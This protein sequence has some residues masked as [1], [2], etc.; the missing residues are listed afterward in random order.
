M[1][2]PEPSDSELDIVACAY[3]S[4]MKSLCAHVDPRLAISSYP[5]VL[6]LSVYALDPGV[7]A[8]PSTSSSGQQS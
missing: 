8:P 3:L 4:A 2:L 1:N 5:L 6:L 7:V